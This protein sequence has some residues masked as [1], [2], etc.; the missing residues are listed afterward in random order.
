MVGKRFWIYTALFLS[1]ACKSKEGAMDNPSGFFD[2]LQNN[3]GL[4]LF[5]LLDNYPSLKAGFQ[6]LQPIPFNDRL[7]GSMTIPY[8]DDIIGFLR[9]SSDMLL[10][11][12]AHVRQSLLKVHNLLDRIEN[13]PNRAF[14]TLQP[15]L[16]NL[17]VYPKPVLRSL[18]PLSQNA[19][20]FMYSTYSKSDMQT[21][22]QELA[23]V[24]RD[25]EIKILFVELEDVLDKALNQNPTTKGALQGL[26]QGMVDPSLIAD[27]VMKQKLIQIISSV[28][29][30]F[31][32]RAGFSDFKSSDTVL[33]ELIINLQKF[34]TAQGS[35]YSDPTLT[36]YTDP[37]YPSEFSI[38][39]TEAFRTLKPMM[40]RGGTF[41]SDPNVILSLKLAQ[42]LANFDFSRN[43]SG[44]D[45]SLK[46]LIRMDSLG[47]DRVNDTTSSPVTALESLMF[48]LTLSDKFGYR[49]ENPADTTMM[50]LEPNGS[51]NGG[52]MTGGVLTVG[53]SIYSL[54]S[55]MT[56]NIGIKSFMNQSSVDGAVF[57]NGDASHPTAFS[58]SINTPT[59][60]LL[61][62]PDPSIVPSATDPVYT[63]TIPFIMKL[64]RKVLL[65]GGGPYYNRN[66]TDS[67]GAIYTIDGNMYKDSNG[68]DLIYKSSWNTSE[69]RIKVSDTASG[70]CSGTGLCR[71]VGPGG[72]ETSANSSDN[73]F[74]SVASGANASGAKGW[75]IPV[76][77]IN[78]D[79]QTQ[80]AVNSDEE[81]IYKNFQWLLHEKRMVAVIPLRASLGVGVPYKMAAFVTLIGNG[82]TG[83]MGAVPILQDGPNC[84]D[85]INGIWRVKQTYLKPGCASST[86]PNFRQPGIPVLQANYSDVPGDSMFYLE[87]W[88]YG[89]TG[90]GPLTFNSLGDTSVYSIFYPPTSSYGVI[91]ESIAANFGVMERLSFLTSNRVLASPADSTYGVSV[92]SA[93]DSRN[94][95]LPLIVALAQTLDDQA[96]ATHNPFQILTGLSGSL[97]RPLLGRIT[98]PETGSGSRQIDVVK[99]MNSD[100]SIRSNSAGPDEYLFRYL[101]PV[102]QKPIRS[103]LSLLAESERRYQDGLLN[104]MSRTELLSTFV[105]MLAEMGTPARATGAALT[106]SSLADFLGE[107]KVTS[108]SPTAIQYNLQTY[109]ESV[110]DL[111][112]SYPTTRS[113]NVY[114]TSWD[115]VGAWAVRLRDYFSTES[116]YS[117]VPMIDFSLDMVIDNVP[118]NSQIAGIL[119]LLGS[120]FRDSNGNQDYLITNLISGDSADLLDIA[121]PNGRSVVGVLLGIVKTGEFYSYL[122]S[123]MNTP[124]PLKAVFTDLKS[125]IVSDM[126]QTPNQD[127]TSLLYTVGVL[128]GIFADM[129]AG[130]RKEMPGGFTFYDRFNQDENSDTYW[131][132][133]TL[134]FS[135]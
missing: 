106:F 42:N 100:S 9:S 135:R 126:I 10:K 53:D 70:T 66:R 131:N 78:K 112:A 84:T 132:R 122:E 60:T 27:R 133:L 13:A 51:V 89:T 87:A 95:L 120:L 25:P 59:L 7:E 41:T 105:T 36:D 55:T 91:P 29:E 8:R 34:Y 108:D 130:G 119:N 44:V 113:T 47:R 3:G 37:V 68:V 58:I 67:T 45:F 21:K 43:I 116:V 82:L 125:L 62:A 85:K 129:A 79:D 33:K 77:E 69:Y 134:I 104:L 88:D 30:S 18:A 114:D 102:T 61:E 76:W 124:Y 81:A 63:K 103:P 35:V 64:V 127:S 28:G 49:W 6:S 2:N 56:G 1:L 17:R 20:S 109:L 11:P 65:S 19:L 80:R 40:S 73:S 111:L 38:V 39:L 121:S 90:S 15:W 86:Q 4:K 110:R 16:E 32:Q 123:D 14:D 5:N 50:R 74:S 23:A 96:D 92:D 72:R 107:I 71:W 46:E 75:S 31:Q 99:I 48:L 52:P 12:E 97:T 101:D 24:L 117:L 57:R 115:H 118:S 83:L 98:D 26:L 22:F 54:G 94:R 93:W 128:T